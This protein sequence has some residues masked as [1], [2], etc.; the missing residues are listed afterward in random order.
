MIGHLA[1]IAL[2]RAGKTP[3]QGV[4]IDLGT[5]D[6]TMARHWHRKHVP[7][8]AAVVWVEDEDQPQ[9]LDLRFVIGMDVVLAVAPGQSQARL[10]AMASVIRQNEPKSLAVVA[11][12][13]ANGIDAA[14]SL[15][16]RAWTPIREV[17][18]WSC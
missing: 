7:M 6:P 8:P 15:V 12:N 1:L 18:L 10:D 13:D 14:W 11:L 3:R 16:D 2:R 4:R 9:A 17:A 5:V